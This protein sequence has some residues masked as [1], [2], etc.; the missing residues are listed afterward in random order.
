VVLLDIGMPRL[1][2]YDTCRRN[3]G[4]PWGRKVVVA[5]LTGWGQKDDTQRAASAGFDHHF[6]M[7]VDPAALEMLLAEAKTPQG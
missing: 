7:P 6:T 4:Q 5:A 1:N 2:C 3:R